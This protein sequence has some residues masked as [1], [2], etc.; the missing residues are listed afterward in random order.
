MVGDVASALD[1][2]GVKYQVVKGELSE[3]ETVW[4]GINPPETEESLDG[5]VDG[6]SSTPIQ[7]IPPIEAATAEASATGFGVEVG[8]DAPPSPALSAV[9]S[10]GVGVPRIPTTEKYTQGQLCVRLRIEP[11]G[12]EQSRLHISRHAGDV[13]QFHS[14]YRDVRNQLAGVNGWVNNHG[15]YEHVVTSPTA[16]P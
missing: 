1:S 3:A 4:V 7:P 13:L 8:F 6:R 10:V 12:S 5:G 11:D 9:S 15:K 16:P 14:F 2:L